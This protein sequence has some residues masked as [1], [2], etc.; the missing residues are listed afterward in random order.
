MLATRSLIDIAERCGGT[1][2]CRDGIA[3]APASRFS[4]VAIDSRNCADGDLFVA[5]VGDHHDGHD[6]IA[7]LDDRPAALVVSELQRESP[8]LQWLV[9]DT[10]VALGQLAQCER[11]YFQGPVIALTGSSGKSSVKEMCASILGLLAP[12][13]AT[14][15]NLN[16]QFGA[17]LTLLSMKPDQRYAVIELGASRVGDI[18]YLAALT[19]AD[20]A[21]VNNIQP[22]HVAGFGSL[23]A[24]AQEK[25][26][27]YRQLGADGIAVIN[28]DE[29]YAA[30]WLQEMGERRVITFS[31]S[32]PSADIGAQAVELSDD[33]CARF[34]LQAD[35][36]SCAVALQIPGIHQVSNALAA[37]ALTRAVGADIETIARGLSAA[38]TLGGR[39][40]VEKLSERVTLIDDSYNAN[41]GS[42][43]AAI[44]LLAA[45]PGL[46]CL[47]LGDMAELGEQAEQWH[48]KIGRYA[49]EKGIETVVA[50]GDLAA[51]AARSAG[52]V[53]CQNQPECLQTLL[54]LAEQSSAVTFLVKGSR[55]AAMD[56][57]SAQ[58]RSEV[59]D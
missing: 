25:S 21:L 1:L 37:A 47:V 38:K 36:Q 55:S 42:V 11:E 58:L 54:S 10:T 51:Q 31:V 16:N 6:F 59:H 41:P 17:P 18:E 44:D 50:V 2:W 33:G 57:L 34:S 53:V 7:G 26:A 4:G 13:L 9:D 46:R 23:Q 8:L 43:Q 30:G 28:L 56:Q 27:I 19:N 5:I 22:A 40:S 48:Q 12:T 24:I 15:G 14:E 52:G 45:M 35:H 32:Q 29:P 39:L 49:S 3:S 20:I